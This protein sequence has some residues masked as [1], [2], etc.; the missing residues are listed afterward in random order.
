M[1]TSEIILLKQ[2]CQHRQSNFF[3][4]LNSLISASYDF[5][6]SNSCTKVKDTIDLKEEPSLG[7]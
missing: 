6:N 3:S 2:P 5:V 4:L 1:L 7:F